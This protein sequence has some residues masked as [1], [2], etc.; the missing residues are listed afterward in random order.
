MLLLRLR[1]FERAEVVRRP[2]TPWSQQVRSG[3]VRG[4]LMISAHMVA[5][6]WRKGAL[7]ERFQESAA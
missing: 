1:E 5:P 7:N 4:T 6:G 3:L 2:A